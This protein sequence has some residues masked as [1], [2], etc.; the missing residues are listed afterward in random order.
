[1]WN[2]K[3]Q[4]VGTLRRFLLRKEVM[5][6]HCT[7]DIVKPPDL[8]SSTYCE[9]DLEGERVGQDLVRLRVWFSSWKL[10]KESFKKKTVI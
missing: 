2:V 5:F 1:M 7:E 9:R 6:Q 4:R 8:D 3:G 10:F